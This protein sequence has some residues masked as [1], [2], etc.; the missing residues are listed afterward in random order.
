MVAVDD[1]VEAKGHPRAPEWEYLCALVREVS[2][3]VASQTAEVEWLEDHCVATVPFAN[4][5]EVGGRGR[6]S[7]TTATKKKEAAIT[8]WTSNI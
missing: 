7:R 4:I 3:G 2:V 6:R 5:R 1:L 8:R